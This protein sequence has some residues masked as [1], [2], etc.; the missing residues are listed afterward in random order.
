MKTF[1]YYLFVIVIGVVISRLAEAVPRVESDKTIPVLL[2]LEQR[3][4]EVLENKLTQ[5]SHL[6]SSYY[7]KYLKA[8][9]IADIIAPSQ[10]ELSSVIKSLKE[11]GAESI[12]IH[13]TRDYISC[14]LPSHQLNRLFQREETEEHVGTEK[15]R[16]SI[17]KPRTDSSVEAVKR[18]VKLAY[19]LEES[20]SDSRHTL[21]AAL[22]ARRRDEIAEK[23]SSSARNSLH[24]FET[25]R[26]HSPHVAE[27]VLGG[28]ND[29][30][31]FL[32]PP[33]PLFNTL[34]T[35]DNGFY[36]LIVPVCADNQLSHYQDDSNHPF[37]CPNTDVSIEEVV[38]YAKDVHNSSLS[39]KK[40]FQGKELSK[41]SYSLRQWC[42]KIYN[43]NPVAFMNYAGY[44]E[45]KVLDE[46]PDIG[47]NI[48][49]LNFS[50]L[51]IFVHR[52]YDCSSSRYTR[53]IL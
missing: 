33:I 19:N 6:A 52:C 4:I 26:K 10:E 3:N 30:S 32:P 44:C 31:P 25:Y 2:Q 40:T 8:E 38:I 13:R 50:R 34:S 36:L 1:S 7:G 17:H 12:Q 35:S 22:G 48:I 51:T 24:K 45:K 23:L 21:L 49:C 47:N 9:D 39:V 15:V 43:S 16:M 41:Y 46:S 28:H 5:I 29:L 37:S 11:V 42:E 27:N 53:C 20:S 14:H 18:Y